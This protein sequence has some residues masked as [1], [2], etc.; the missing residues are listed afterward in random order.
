MHHRFQPSDAFNALLDDLSDAPDGE[1]NQERM[2]GNVV[3]SS[4][5]NYVT[6]ARNYRC[7]DLAFAAGAGGGLDAEDQFDL[8]ADKVRFVLAFDQFGKLGC[9]RGLN[10]ILRSP[11]PKV[12]KRLEHVAPWCLANDQLPAL[13][14]SPERFELSKRFDVWH[15]QI[16]DRLFVVFIG[17]K[18]FLVDKFEAADA[19]NGVSEGIDCTTDFKHEKP[20]GRERRRVGAQLKRVAAT[21]EH[22]C[23]AR[24]FG[25]DGTALTSII[26]W[27]GT[28]HS[29]R[30]PNG[31]GLIS[32]RS[33]PQQ[34]LGPVARHL[35]RQA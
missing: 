28:G 2:V 27:F 16:G 22:F 6:A 26:E 34:W 3:N 33:Q 20:F 14:P 23:Q 19:L 32:L 1:I 15:E 11:G 4:A 7:P 9:I 24:E 17:G 10:A 18:L 29:S 8:Q 30:R 12:T 35:V 31:T 25:A 5:G 21:P 13:P